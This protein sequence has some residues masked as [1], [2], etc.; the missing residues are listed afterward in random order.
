MKN[1]YTNFN[2]IYFNISLSTKGGQEFLIALPVDKLYVIFCKEIY[3][4]F[5]GWKREMKKPII[6]ILFLYLV[7]GL[8]HG[9]VSNGNFLRNLTSRRIKEIKQS[10]QE[11]IISYLLQ[12][13]GFSERAKENLTPEMIKYLPEFF[14]DYLIQ[15]STQKSRTLENY[16]DL[17]KEDE[18]ERNS[19][20]SEL[21]SSLKI[22]PDSFFTCFFRFLSDVVK[23]YFDE[24]IPSKVEKQDYSWYIKSVAG[25]I[26]A[27]AYS[28]AMI[29]HDRLETY[30]RDKLFANV[31]KEE[32]E[33][34][35]EEWIKR[36]R[37]TIE[38]YDIAT[39]SLLI[40]KQGRY[41]SALIFDIQSSEVNRS[42]YDIDLLSKYFRDANE[43]NLK[44]ISPTLQTWVYPKYIDLEKEEQLERLKH[45]HEVAFF[46]HS[47]LPL[48]LKGKIISLLAKFFN[49]NY[50][51]LLFLSPTGYEII[52]P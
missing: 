4:L 28:I 51:G 48:R 16:L 38:L 20:I 27:E 18:A 2:I 1:I 24:Q 40:A 10:F 3:L 13:P 9:I 52:P 32:R 29:L 15:K 46:M 7:L 11:R 25:A 12:Q 6:V 44:E 36:W 41:D 17:L 19:L 26:G 5:L 39:A 45:Q 8:S 34:M 23:N 30:A 43:P 49:P 14:L 21:D 31:P 22:D 42:Q 33:K 50:K 35:V 37:I 47:L